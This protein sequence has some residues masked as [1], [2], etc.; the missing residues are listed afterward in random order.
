MTQARWLGR[1]AGNLDTDMSV[2]RRISAKPHQVQ[3]RVFDARNTRWDDH[4]LVVRAELSD[5]AVRAI[6]KCGQGVSMED[7]AAEAGVSKPKLY[8][9]FGDKAGLYRAVGSRLG[10]M[11]WESA[12]LTLQDAGSAPSVDE[13]FGSL[14]RS[15]VRLV[16]KHPAVVR[17]LISHKMFQYSVS[18][19]GGA[20]DELRSIVEILA[21]QFA[22]HLRTIDADTST[23]PIVVASI[24]GSGLSATEWW[25]DGGAE[26]G[27]DDELFIAHLQDTTWGI[28]E[29]ASRR[30]GV[31]FS[32][33]R[34]I[35]DVGFVTRR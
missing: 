5:A 15:Y 35:S 29:A 10:T 28:V 17:F 34:S 13:V 2:I 30:L 32:R 9:H 31:D 23:V 3:K 24:L 12:E 11:I 4:R 21:E 6:D 8:R 19:D 20:A 16:A 18:G 27:V 1:T 26:Q 22:T 7:I 33:D 25:L 14:I